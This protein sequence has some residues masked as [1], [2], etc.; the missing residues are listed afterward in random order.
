META[1]TVPAAPVATYRG[2][3][4]LELP[5]DLYIPPDA[6]EIFHR[7]VRGAVVDL[8]PYPDP[9]A[10]LYVPAHPDGAPDRTLSRTLEIMRQKS[11]ELAGDLLPRLRRILIE[12][13]SRCA[14]LRR[15]ALDPRAKIKPRLLAYEQMKRA[16]HKLD[17]TAPGGARFSARAGVGRQNR[18][19][20]RCRRSMPKT[21]GR[22]GCGCCSARTSTSITALLRATSCP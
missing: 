21:C 4:L 19:R 7:H 6:L 2:E 5:Q 10:Q 22:H 9:Q 12:I 13:M 14:S 16:A 17:A 15:P 20:R 3:P 8:L 18:S 11:L 1:D